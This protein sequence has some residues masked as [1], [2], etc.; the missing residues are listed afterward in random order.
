MLYTDD[1]IDQATVWNSIIDAAD[2]KGSEGAE[3]EGTRTATTIKVEGE[4]LS[5]LSVSPFSA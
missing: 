1:D 5:G 4:A 3:V 2:A